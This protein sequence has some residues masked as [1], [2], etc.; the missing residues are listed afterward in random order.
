MI[1]VGYKLYAMCV[2]QQ[3][4]RTVR[5]KFKR[6]KM[7]TSLRKLGHKIDRHIEKRKLK[8]AEVRYIHHGLPFEAE[9]E[10][11]KLEDIYGPLKEVEG[12]RDEMESDVVFLKYYTPKGR[13]VAEEV[14]QRGLVKDN[15]YNVW[16]K[17]IF[18][19]DVDVS[20]TPMEDK[21]EEVEWLE[22]EMGC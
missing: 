8:G 14:R 12:S 18:L 7:P 13:F 22:D 4:S 16:S 21:W 2:T 17:L 6:D 15:V 9:W 1:E 3:M 5:S 20:I 19:A 11:S 10:L